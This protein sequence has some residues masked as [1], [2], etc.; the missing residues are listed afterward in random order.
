MIRD[1]QFHSRD[2]LVRKTKARQDFDGHFRAQPSMAG[3][4][5]AAANGQRTRFRHIVKKSRQGK[6]DGRRCKIL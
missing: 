6:R 5:D 2:F 4:A 3:K 1:Q